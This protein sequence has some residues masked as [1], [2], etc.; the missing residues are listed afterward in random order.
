MEF[1]ILTIAASG[2]TLILT[3]S[4][5]FAWLQ[6]LGRPFDCTRCMGAWV[7]WAFAVTLPPLGVELPWWQFYALVPV[8][9]LVANSV[10][11][12]DYFHQK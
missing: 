12:M 8:T 5:A 4:D 3:Q 11:L 9:S 10:W 6:K 2:L 1:W 7:G